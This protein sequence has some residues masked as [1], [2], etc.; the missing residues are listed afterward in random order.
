MRQERGKIN[1]QVRA[2]VSSVVVFVVVELVDKLQSF[3]IVSQ[4]RYV[5]IYL[6][7]RKLCI[8]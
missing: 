8:A 4:P 6:Y 7:M 1:V 5:R 3:A 2:Q